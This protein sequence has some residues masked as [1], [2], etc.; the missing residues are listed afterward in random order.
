MNIIESIVATQKVLTF[1]REKWEKKYSEYLKGTIRQKQ[2]IAERR[3]RF[4]K[5]GAL[6]VYSSIG[7]AYKNSSS[8]DIRY[9]GQSVG[10]I[11][12]NDREDVYLN[13]TEEHDSRSRKYFAGYP[14]AIMPGKHKWTSPTAAAFRRFFS[15]SVGKQGHPEHRFEN[16]LLKQFNKNCGKDKSI[17]QIQP[18]T[19]VKDVF[20]QMPTPLTAS[21]DRIKYSEN[22]KGGI[23]ILARYKSS[24]GP[25]RVILQALAYATF[26]VELIKTEYGDLFWDLCKIRNPQNRKLINVSILMPD[27]NDNSI[28]SFAGDEI[29]VPDSDIRFK[30]HYMYFDKETVKITRTSL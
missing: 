25:D 26:V 13:I 15:Q 30:L 14:K 2:V 28:P 3:S 12:V 6:N 11:S 21:K 18:V 23:D 17:T 1:N 19:L 16:M 10:E 5:W 22:G 9:L 4:K 7:K 20:F 27:P 8:F 24:E 29:A